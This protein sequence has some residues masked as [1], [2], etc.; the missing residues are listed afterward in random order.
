MELLDVTPIPLATDRIL[1]PGGSAL[2]KRVVKNALIQA[3]N[4]GTTDAKL[5]ALWVQDLSKDGGESQ[6]RI[7][8]APGSVFEFE[9]PRNG[10]QFL[11]SVIL[12]HLSGGEI[13]F[14]M[15]M[16]ADQLN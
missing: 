2:C 16:P 10:S 6:F 5:L 11:D 8:I 13:R 4:I 15:L 1:G 9:P 14:T 12:D 3:E 7:S